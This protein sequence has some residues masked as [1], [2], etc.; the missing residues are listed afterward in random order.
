MTKE[1]DEY[2]EVLYIALYENSRRTPVRLAE[3]QF[4]FVRKK[5]SIFRHLQSRFWSSDCIEV[6]CQYYQTTS[7]HLCIDDMSRSYAW[8]FTYN[9]PEG[10]DADTG[11][12]LHAGG[13]KYSVYQRERGQAGTDHHQGYVEFG[14]NK[15]LSFV[16]RLLPLAHWETR[17]GSQKQAIDYCSKE[18]TRVAGPYYTGIPRELSQGQRSDISD[19]I[20][21]LR[22]GG[23]A[24]VRAD[25]P[26][27]FVKYSRGLRELDLADVKQ[28]NDRRDVTLIFG[29][30]GCGKT[31]RFFDEEGPEGTM[32]LCSSGFWFDGYEGQPAVLLDDFDGCRSKWTLAQTLMVLD[33]YVVRVPIKGSFTR[34]CPERISVT[35]NIHP[36]EWFEWGSREQQWPALIRRFTRVIWFRNELDPPTILI[37]TDGT[38]LH[39]WSWRESAQLTLDMES[40]KLVSRAPTGGYFDF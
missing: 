30:P 20:D 24:A 12:V 7:L 29:P 1:T 23:M 17:K 26:E 36:R 4:F 18:D 28:T 19:A 33:R 32:L 15:T 37:P 21:L 11:R 14:N 16:R 39:F 27:V 8:L 25:S 2:E 6:V 38:W 3:T 35:T 40:G 10:G 34:W 13:A 9:N 22:E 31:R 5:P